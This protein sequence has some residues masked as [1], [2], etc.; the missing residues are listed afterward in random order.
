MLTIYQHW[1]KKFRSSDVYFKALQTETRHDCHA[2]VNSFT[3]LQ[4]AKKFTL[5]IRMFSPILQ[6]VQK[7]ETTMESN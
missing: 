1:E 6:H 4:N 3:T 5:Q 7:T 2:I